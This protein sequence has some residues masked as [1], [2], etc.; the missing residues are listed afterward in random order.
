VTDYIVCKRDGLTAPVYWGFFPYINP[1][2]NY[3][4]PTHNTRQMPLQVTLS[5]AISLIP[6][7][8]VVTT[9]K[10]AGVNANQKI[11]T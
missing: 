1:A 9:Q 4:F 10:L 3:T 7:L 8:R 6:M 11:V 2:I 5:E